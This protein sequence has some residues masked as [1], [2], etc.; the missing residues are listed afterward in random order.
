MR[1]FTVQEL[2]DRIRLKANIEASSGYEEFMTDAELRDWL[3]DAYT[4]LLDELTSQ[5]IWSFGGSARY[6]AQVTGS[7]A[8]YALPSGAYKIRAI[9]VRQ[10]NGYWSEAKQVS[11]RYRNVMQGTTGWSVNQVDVFT[12]QASSVAWYFSDTSGGTQKAITFIPSPSG[13]EEFRVLYIPAVTG[14]FALT[15]TI[16]GHNGFEEWLVL[17]VADRVRTKMLEPLEGIK[18]EKANVLTRIRSVAGRLADDMPKTIVDVNDVDGG[19]RW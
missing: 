11:P 18:E 15:D 16:E 3:T 19:W 14:S 1:T 5:D 2:I 17:E 10:Q 6:Q 13:T 4:K 8:A 7:Q 9:D 12:T